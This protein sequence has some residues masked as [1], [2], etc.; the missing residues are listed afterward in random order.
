[1]KIKSV[2]E[3]IIIQIIMIGITVGVYCIALIFMA[4]YIS[5]S[6]AL[7]STFC[8]FEALIYEIGLM[9]ILIPS[10]ILRLIFEFSVGNK[11]CHCDCHMFIGGSGKSCPNCKKEKCSYFLEEIR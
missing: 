9:W 8:V 6:V 7:C 10:V 5:S 11:K 4:S 1:M 2:L 3:F